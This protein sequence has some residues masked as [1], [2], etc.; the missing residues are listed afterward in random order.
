MLVAFRMSILFHHC[1]NAAGLRPV[2]RGE[3][4]PHGGGGRGARPRPCLAHH[5]VTRQG[6]DIDN[7][8]VLSVAQL[9]ISIHKCKRNNNKSVK[10]I[11]FP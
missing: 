1:V 2:V 6:S 4:L 5:P 8:L 11:A 3:R 9:E 10:G 7:S